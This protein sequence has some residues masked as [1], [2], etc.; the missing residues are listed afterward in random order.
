MKGFI[1]YPTYRV[2]DGKPYACLYGRLE[3][4]DSFLTI[5]HA[6]PYFYIKKL[7][8]NTATSLADFDYGETDFKDFSGNSVVKILLNVPSEV[9]KLRELLSMN[10]ISSYEADVRYAYRF[11]I[12]NNLQSSLDLSLIHI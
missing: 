12:D 7:D 5:N 10:D 1:T 4:G 8:L 6:R 9:P 2:I 11:M 3:N